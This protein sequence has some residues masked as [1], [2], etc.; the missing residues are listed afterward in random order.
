ELCMAVDNEDARGI[1]KLLVDLVQSS[2]EAIA[3]L[4]RILIVHAALGIHQ[5][6]LGRNTRNIDTRSA[7]HLRGLLHQNNA[8]AMLRAVHGNGLA[9]LTKTDNQ[10][11]RGSFSLIRSEERRVGKEWRAWGW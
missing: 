7:V 8:V 4:N 11:I 2:D 6:G 1:G 3:V 9:G 10:H 5:H